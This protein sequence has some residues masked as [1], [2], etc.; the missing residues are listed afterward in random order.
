SRVGAA[1]KRKDRLRL[2]GAGRP[3][4][5][6]D[7]EQHLQH[8]MAAEIGKAGGVPGDR[9]GGVLR[10]GHGAAEDKPGAGGISGC[11]GARARACVLIKTNATAETHRRGE[12]SLRKL[13][14]M[15]YA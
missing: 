2:G 10:P 1:E 8:G 13:E 9:P 4:R 3:G 14:T 15:K 5:V 11:A 6:G 12:E 7:Q